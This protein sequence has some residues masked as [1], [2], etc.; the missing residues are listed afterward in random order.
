M[1][2]AGRRNDFALPFAAMCMYNDG[3]KPERR[4]IRA[5]ET[6]VAERSEILFLT[7]VAARAISREIMA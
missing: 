6:M 3:N 7:R 5:G 1:Y 4:G 2:V